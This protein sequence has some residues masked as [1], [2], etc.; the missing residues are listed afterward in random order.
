[1]LFYSK[2]GKFHRQNRLECADRA[3]WSEMGGKTIIALGD[4]VSTCE[5]GDIGAE[6]ATG[7]AVDFLVSQYHRLQFL[8][9]NWPYLMVRKV[10]SQLEE[11]AAYNGK[12]LIEYSTTLLVAIIDRDENVIH[13]S[14]IGDGMML[15]I[16]SQCCKILSSPTRE[17]EGCPTITTENIEKAVSAQTVSL[18]GIRDIMLCTDGTWTQ[19]YNNQKL[20]PS[21]KQELLKA[22]YDRFTFRIQQADNTDDSCFVIIDGDRSVA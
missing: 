12:N 6:L 15:G 8:P 1:M 3:K 2:K 19:I 21:V 4:G 17:I 22:E 14:N 13:F 11:Y 16:Q 20:D 18:N 9:K 10:R 5:C 7:Y